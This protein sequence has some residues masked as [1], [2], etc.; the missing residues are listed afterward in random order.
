M[1]PFKNLLAH[2]GSLKK[3][4]SASLEELAEAKGIGPVLA[5]A[6]FD[7][8]N[9]AGAGAGSVEEA[10]PAVNMTTGEILD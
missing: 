7:C 8:V 6:I 10:A 1:E 4:R 3:I 2:F 5:Q 9:A